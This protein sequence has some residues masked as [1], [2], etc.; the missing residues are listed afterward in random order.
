MPR[1]VAW[2]MALP[3]TLA[4]TNVAE[5]TVN[6]GEVNARWADLGYCWT[7]SS[8]RALSLTER[9][10]IEPRTPDSDG[11]LANIS[12]DMPGGF[13]G[14]FYL[15]GEP[16]MYLVE[17]RDHA[18]L[19]KRLLDEKVIDEAPRRLY[20]ARWTWVQLYDWRLYIG[21]QID[22]ERIG[23]ATIDI[24]EFGNRIDLGVP[25]DRRWLAE[26]QLRDLHIPCYLVALYDTDPILTH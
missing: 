11:E 26:R 13:G 25:S 19:T 23:Y 8:A 2:L 15:H 16:S 17:P 20:R 7:G 24:N 22:H 6:A 12:R 9:L 5:P 14:Y 3:I 18:A 10:R 21:Q 1:R 4:C